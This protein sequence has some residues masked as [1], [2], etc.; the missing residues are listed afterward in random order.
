MSKKIKDLMMKDMGRRFEE[1]EAV[2]VIN[3]RGIDAVRNNQIR[4]RLREQN[5]HMTVVRN[6][7]AKRV[8][9]DGALKGFDA[10][11]DGPTALVYGEVSISTIARLL[12]AE[13][14]EAEKLELRGVF[15]DGDVYAGQEG[16]EK[17]SKFPTREEAVANILGALLGPGRKL[18]GALKGPGGKIGGI[19]KSIEE[20]AGEG[21][22]AAAA[23]PAA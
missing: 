14:K 6:T 19:L 9:N 15:F 20:K 7:L 21:S 18:A 11:L 2:A 22:P 23:A 10:L 13:K 16:M 17:V 5:V 4:R 3:P 8:L 12:I 1:V